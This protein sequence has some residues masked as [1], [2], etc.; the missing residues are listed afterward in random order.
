MR[1][2][3]AKTFRHEELGELDWDDAPIELTRAHVKHASGAHLGASHRG[4]G[5]RQAAPVIDDPLAERFL[6]SEPRYDVEEDDD[7][8]AADFAWQQ[9]GPRRFM[10]KAI[11]WLAI[12]GCLG[13]VFSVTQS[14][15]ARRE[16]ARWLTLGNNG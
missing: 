16:V 2:G 7:D 5:G 14:E 8:L 11:G 9:R 4:F 3:A 15:G 1:S 13:C 6:R 12:L 10:V